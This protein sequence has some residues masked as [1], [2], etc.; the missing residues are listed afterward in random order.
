MLCQNCKK[1]QAE[2]FIVINEGDKTKKLSLC[3]NC[4][5]DIYKK[6][7][8]ETFNMLL[9][10]FDKNFGDVKR[11]P[12]CG[13]S[14][15]EILES[16]KVGCFNCVKTFGDEINKLVEKIHGKKVYKGKT[17]LF[18]G[19]KREEILRSKILLSKAIEEE[20]YEKAAK[21]RDYLKNLEKG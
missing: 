18:H 19:D 2:Y 12:T 7:L 17:P 15:D 20:D 5:I 13:R 4:F 14:L 6:L 1:E 11:C 10:I 21:I 16:K 8:G 3:R 9:N